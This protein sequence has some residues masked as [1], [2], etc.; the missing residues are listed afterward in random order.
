VE[1]SKWG[2]RYVIIVW[3]RLVVVSVGVSIVVVI[4]IIVIRI[5]AI[6]CSHLLLLIVGV[7]H[8]FNCKKYRQFNFTAV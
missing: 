7:G 8:D 6:A 2:M 3:V 1:A 4:H 5:G